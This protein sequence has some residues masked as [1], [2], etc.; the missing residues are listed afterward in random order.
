MTAVESLEEVLEEEPWSRRDV[1]RSLYVI[2]IGEGRIKVGIGA[3]PEGRL[4]SHR[5]LA[6]AHGVDSGRAWVTPPWAT[7]ATESALINLCAAQST[8]QF[9][10]EYFAGV[11]FEDAVSHAASVSGYTREHLQLRVGADHPNTKWQ[12]RHVLDLLHTTED[13]VRA[14]V[15]AGDL[16]SLEFEDESYIVITRRALLDWMFAGPDLIGLPRA[17]RT[18]L[19]EAA[20]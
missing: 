17:P 3:D 14:L 15:A 18:T 6:F 9:R 1:P 2:E 5:S 7:S 4:R 13:A 8:A 19:A 16:K 11:T 12:L 10:R 20:S